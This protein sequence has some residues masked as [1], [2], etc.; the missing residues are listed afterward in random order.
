MFDIFNVSFDTTRLVHNK[1]SWAIIHGPDSMLFD[2]EP[3]GI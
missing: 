3:D 2:V 1:S